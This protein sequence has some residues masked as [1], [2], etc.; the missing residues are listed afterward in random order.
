MSRLE[1]LFQIAP[2]KVAFLRHASPLTQELGQCITLLLVR[3]FARPKKLNKEHDE[4]D[5]E[6]M[7]LEKVTKLLF[8]TC[9]A[10]EDAYFLIHIFA[11][12]DDTIDFK[13]DILGET[14]LKLLSV[15]K[16]TDDKVE[17]ASDPLVGLTANSV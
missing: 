10:D 2:E 12:L 7:T 9:F 1:A 5:L 6:I 8:L 4:G 15:S 3:N 13:S 14:F 17:L 16:T 11:I